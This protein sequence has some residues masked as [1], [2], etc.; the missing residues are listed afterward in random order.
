[1]FHVVLSVSF[2]LTILH[3]AFDI[4]CAEISPGETEHPSECENTGTF[5]RPAND[6]I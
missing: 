6:S 5:G 3:K 1:M 2:G 4:G